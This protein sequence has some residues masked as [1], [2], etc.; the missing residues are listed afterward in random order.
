MGFSC[1]AALQ[2]AILLIAAK[3]SDQISSELAQHDFDT[4]VQAKE[5]LERLTSNFEALSAQHEALH[6][7][8]AKINEQLTGETSQ[9][10]STLGQ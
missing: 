3:R 7:Q 1:L 9:Q 2:G 10:A 4:D 6:Q 5:L 8:I